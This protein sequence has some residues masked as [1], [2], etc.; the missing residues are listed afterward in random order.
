MVAV[1]GLLEGIPADVGTVKLPLMLPALSA[2]TVVRGVVES[3]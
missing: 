2:L 3:P 1:T